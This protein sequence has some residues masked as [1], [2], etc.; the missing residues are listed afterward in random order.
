MSVLGILLLALAAQDTRPAPKPRQDFVRIE[1]TCTAL[2]GSSVYLDQGREAGF[3]P[4]DRVRLFPRVGPGRKGRISSVSRTSARAELEGGLDGLEIGLLGEVWVPRARLEPPAAPATESVPDSEPVTEATPPPPDETAAP[5][6]HPP[7]TAPPEEWNHAQPLLAPAHGLAPEERPRRIDGR[8]FTSFDW[9]DDSAGDERREFLASSLGFDARIENPFAHGGELAFD[10]E[11]FS[12]HSD[13]GGET[14]DES[15]LRID[16]ASYSWGG[17]RG[18]RDHGEVGRFLQSELPALG[19]LDGFE[20]VRQLGVKNR[21]GASVGF[22]PVPDDVFQSGDDLQAALFWRRTSGADQRLSVAGGYQKTWHE[23]AADR[24]LL[25]GELEYF[26]GPRTSLTGSALVDLYTSGDE[27][28]GAGPE[29]TQL[30]VNATQRTQAG[31]GVSLFLSRF[32]WPELERDEFP[33]VTAA[34]IADALT[35][36]YG[37]DGWLALGRHTQLYGRADAWSDQDD[38]GGGGRL[39]LTWRDLGRHR[40]VLVLES[41][42]TRSK[43]TDA[44]GLRASARRRLEHAA[45]DLS[46]DTTLFE[47]DDVDEDLLQHAVRGGVELGLGPRWFLALYAESRFGDE[48]DALSLGFLLQRSFER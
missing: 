17:V 21:V 23:G 4:G 27:L 11:V 47:Q 34:E 5:V 46:W 42:T 37:G 28:K 40:D 25:V 45:F 8:V 48:Q 7:W 20:Y 31:H 33:D 19:F 16:R 41:F 15:H 13:S 9:T 14:E 32:R 2:S 26:P 35:T 39:R 6:E 38:S 36:R 30:F 3:A 44:L 18:A 24:D 10:A 1:V 43:F 29:L 12:R 22:L